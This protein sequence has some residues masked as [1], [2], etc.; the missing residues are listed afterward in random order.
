MMI[1]SNEI[2]LLIAARAKEID[3]F[4]KEYPEHEETMGHCRQEILS[5]G[6][7]L[8]KKY[9]FEKPKKKAK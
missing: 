7:T 5:F 9:P 1:D 4:I 8:N 6:V 2:H 3:K